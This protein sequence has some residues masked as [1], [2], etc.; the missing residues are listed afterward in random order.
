MTVQTGS[1][2]VQQQAWAHL[3]L[4]SLQLLGAIRTHLQIDDEYTEWH[5]D[6]F[7]WW[8]AD[9][10]QR[11]RVFE[12]RTSEG[13]SVRWVSFTSDYLRG[14]PRGHPVIDTHLHTLHTSTEL[15]IAAQVGDKIS[16]TSRIATGFLSLDETARLLAD[17]AVLTDNIINAKAGQAVAGMRAFGPE[18]SRVEPNA[19]QHPGAGR[20]AS[21]HCMATAS[22]DV[23]AIQGHAPLPPERRPDLRQLFIDLVSKHHKVY[24]NGDFTLLTVEG[25]RAGLDF[26][27][28]VDLKERNRVMG[29]GIFVK[30]TLNLPGSLSESV[31]IG[32]P[33]QFNELE[34]NYAGAQIVAGGWVLY[35]SNVDRPA[36]P[37]IG[38]P[39]AR[40]PAHPI[41]V[42][43]TYYPQASVTA[44]LA[45]AAAQDGLVRAER[46]AMWLVGSGVNN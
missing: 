15:V 16:L 44:G 4:E 11:F 39:P 46:S 10:A 3:D 32:L 7:T 6:G 45:K 27:L 30:L 31:L 13:E 29:S 18:F 19:S 41:L 35:A 36:D 43:G 8:L 40:W 28:T 37:I 2:Q 42:H 21:R 38:I 25:Q 23:Y 9:F 34:W 22:R 17:R 5:E 33:Q 1:L 14:V 24:V 20:R 26:R 12:T